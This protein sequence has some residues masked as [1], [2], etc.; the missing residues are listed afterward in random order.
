[1]KA[2]TL[3]PE[4]VWAICCLQKRVE[5]RGWIPPASMLGETIAIHAGKALGGGGYRN[6]YYK[7]RAMEM[8][9]QTA[10][11]AGWNYQKN[12]DCD[13]SLQMA[14]G[15][16]HPEWGVIASLSS[17]E[18]REDLI[19]TGA[20]VAT[21]VLDRVTYRPEEDG[22]IVYG[23]M[24]PPWGVEGAKHWRLTD[25]RLLEEPVECRGYQRLWGVPPEVAEK[26]VYD[27]DRQIDR[28]MQMCEGR[29]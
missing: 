6:V 12:G 11:T 20:I 27:E 19:P 10:L 8:V 7:D 23:Y 9:C 21:A 17:A 1:M 3:W 15:R 28:W 18:F 26:M 16:E 24:N 14:Y 29:V 22:K 13:Y 25:V 2:I 5:N 4:W